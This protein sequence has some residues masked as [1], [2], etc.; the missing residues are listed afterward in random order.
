MGNI[1]L[2]TCIITYRMNDFQEGMV[3][4]KSKFPQNDKKRGFLYDFVS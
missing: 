2:V 1:I 3:R 4:A